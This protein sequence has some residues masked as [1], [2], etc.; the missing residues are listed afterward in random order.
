MAQVRS[1]R[2][3]RERFQRRTLPGAPP[4]TIVPTPGARESRASLISFG[5]EGFVEGAVTRVDDIPPLLEQWPVTWIN[6][7]GLGDASLIQEIGRLFDLHRL[8]LEDVVHVHQR[9][10]AENYGDYFFVVAR[11]PLPGRV[12]ETEQISFFFGERFVLTFQERIGG[13]CLEA[14]RTRIRTGWGRARCAKP[15]CLFYALLDVIVD[16]YFPLIEECGERLD[17]VEGQ[18]MEGVQAETMPRLH[19]IKRDLMTVRR[20]MWPLRD[21]LNTLLRDPSPLIHP[22]THVYL[23]DVHD[24]TIQIVDLVESYRDVVSGLTDVYLSTVSQRTNEVMRVLTIIATLFIPLTFL[25]GIYGMNF[26]SDV[27]F[28]NMPELH[29]RYGYPAI[30]LLM[31]LITAGQIIFFVHKGWIRLPAWLGARRA[32]APPRS[33]DH[34]D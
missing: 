6:V 19:G 9:A 24:H 21:A 32:E 20:I 23:R 31:A 33:S 16:H 7:D 28:W 13:D 27:S 34:R 15:D 11:M 18:V 12:W 25:V 10:K 3:R 2:L 4:G 29:W 5:A 14:V 26:N 17:E 8:A 22:E 1:R 30:L